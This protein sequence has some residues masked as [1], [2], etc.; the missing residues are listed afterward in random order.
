MV[1]LLSGDVGLDA[2]QV[3]VA[4]RKVRIAV[5]PVEPPEFSALSLNPPIRDAFWLLYPGRLRDR[6]SE[7]RKDVDMVLDAAH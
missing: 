3:R 4:D 5:L 6:S 2:I 7:P 1:L